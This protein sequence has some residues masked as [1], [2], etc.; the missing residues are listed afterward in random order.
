M[1]RRWWPRHAPQNRGASIA[2][3]AAAL[4][5][6]ALSV[7]AAL[8]LSFILAGPAAAADI[9]IRVGHFPNV[10]HVQALVA[11]G[12]EREGKSWFTSRLG[13]NVKIEWYAYNAG[14]SAMEAIFANSIDLTYVGPNPALNAY[15]RSRGADV[16]V[17]AGAVNGASA[18]VV[19]KDSGLKKPPIFAASG[20]ARR[21]SAIR[22]MSPRAHG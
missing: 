22:R 15:S 13:P 19:Q 7:L 18:L 21:N 17:V 6:K 8:V 11:R 20:S 5:A 14:P 9:T 2:T 16:R 12:L 4:G 1:D 10:T 3:G